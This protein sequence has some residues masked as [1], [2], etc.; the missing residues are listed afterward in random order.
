MVL[1]SKRMF[2]GI[3]KISFSFTS[4]TWSRY[5][6]QALRTDAVTLLTGAVMEEPRAVSKQLWNLLYNPHSDVPPKSSGSL[7]QCMKS[8]LKFS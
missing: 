8:S 7:G 2:A 6:T 4:T 5:G 1:Q 3:K